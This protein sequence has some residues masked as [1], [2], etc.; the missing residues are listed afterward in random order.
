MCD[1]GKGSVYI[2][3]NIYDK[4]HMLFRK[5]TMFNVK[6]DLLAGH[7]TEVNIR[8]KPLNNGPQYSP[9]SLTAK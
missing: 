6:F 5:P 8:N 7:A 2:V 4:W 1:L 3:V 9:C